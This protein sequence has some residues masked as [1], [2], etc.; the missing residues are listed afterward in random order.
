MIL[1][2]SSTVEHMVVVGSGVATTVVYLWAWTRVP[3]PRRDGA[4][5]FCTAIAL[6]L[7]A[8]APSAEARADASFTAHMVQHLLMYCLV[9]PLLVIARPIAVLSAVLPASARPWMLR[10]PRPSRSSPLLATVATVAVLY[11]LHLTPLYD[12]ALDGNGVHIVTHA[13][14]LAA[15]LLVWN[16]AF[17]PGVGDGPV[18]VGIAITLNVPIAILGL[19]LTTSATPFSTHYALTLGETQALAD[20]KAGGAL[21]WI[22][23][24]VAG[25]VLVATTLWRWASREQAIAERM[26][27]LSISSDEARTGLARWADEIGRP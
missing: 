4:T 5:S 14:L 15:G 19:I 13:A 2:H 3:N 7:A 9:P 18:R 22:G 6:L 20:Q 23:A 26:E 11:T 1:A 16:V 10:L 17:K 21:M 12:A 27:Q 8:T 24:M 25:A